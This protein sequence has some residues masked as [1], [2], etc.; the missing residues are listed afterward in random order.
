MTV[1]EWLGDKQLPLDIWHKK[2][3]FENETFDAWLDRVSGSNAA[4]KQLII[5]KKFLFGG[6]ILA[7]RGLDKLGQKVTL[8]NC[9]VVAPP[10][11]SIEGIFECAAKLAR[12]FSFGGGVGI[13]IS[14][15]AP[16]GARVHNT[17][18][19]T[20]GAVS[21]MDLYS[22]ITGLIGQNGRRGALMISM[23]C[24][25]PDIEEFIDIKKDL[26][27]VTKANISIRMTDEFMKAVENDEDFQLK[28]TRPETG[29]FIGKTIKARELFR[30]IAESNHEMGEPGI[31][32]WDTIENYNLLNTNE[33]F[34]YAG[35]NPCAE[36]P[37][38]AGGS[39]LLG[40]VNL[41]AFVK[42][43]QFDFEDFKQTVRIAIVGLNEVL[44]EGL[45][46]HPL[47]EQR[48]SVNDWRQI[49]C[50]IMGLAD[51]LIKMEIRYGSPEAV[52]LCDKIGN[53]M[54]AT[55]IESSA[56]YAATVGTYPR[57]TNDVFQSEF[58]K[59][60]A[61]N[62]EVNAAGV[63][64]LANSQLLTI[65]PTGSLST[66]LGI[67]GGIE[68]VFANYYERKT[69][70]LHNTDQYYKVYTPIVEEYM[71]EHGL[72]DDSELPEWFVTAQS[73]NY[74]ERIEMQ[75][76]WQ[77]HIDA[78][79]S[80]TV[81][82]PEEFTVDQV[83]DLYMY[84]WKKKLKGITMFRANCNRMAV[85]STS[86]KKEEPKEQTQFNHIVPVSRKTLGTTH[87]NTYCKKTACGT[88]Y[89]TVNR[90]DSGNVVE[91][92]VSTSKGGIC[93]ANIGAVNRMV[94]V[95]LRA[96]VRVDEIADQLKGITCQA[97]AKMMTKGEKLDGISCADILG[98][99]LMEFAEC[100]CGSCAGCKSKK[101][102]TKA[103]PNVKATV[104]SKAKCPECGEAVAFEGGC[105]KCMSCGWSKC[106]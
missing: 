75:A 84:A 24:D 55:A 25:H 33:A 78:S 47:Q 14:N 89:V 15:L 6:R 93:Q 68:P 77:N 48:D 28:F 19:T 74:K 69:E 64:G 16:R 87:G 79:I 4:I 40:S 106:E 43:K 10:C 51:A 36:E 52:T 94:S 91:M 34:A 27:R 104:S 54:A 18:K 81:N 35:T 5:D 58:F 71:K 8:S 46:L 11:D 37:L 26:D 67:S 53:V 9:Y 86:P 100:D 70:S 20:S 56:A 44:M 13:D 32:F 38:P 22:L 80:S 21:F 72:T 63:H 59:A 3:Q 61:N 103:K 62:Y 31:L 30:K 65:A 92:F 102:E 2:Y 96:G 7:N 95:A 97:C 23:R 29:E 90:D 66:M 85:L 12:T 82:V 1:Q 45:P 83:M 73:I 49:G 101:T 57:F 60:H 88:L 99:T 42:D 50:G 39:C 98:K 105:M 76:A 17:A 41:A